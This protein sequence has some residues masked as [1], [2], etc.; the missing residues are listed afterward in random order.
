MEI[1]QCAIK[2]SRIGM[3]KNFEKERNDTP[4]Y[5]SRGCFNGPAKIDFSRSQVI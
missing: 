5:P 1:N 4:I 2:K 3:R